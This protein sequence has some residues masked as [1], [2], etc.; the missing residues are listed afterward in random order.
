MEY[1]IEKLL[2]GLESQRA[3]TLK[4]LNELNEN[5]PNYALKCNELNTQIINIDNQITNLILAL[6]DL[7]I[8]ELNNDLTIKTSK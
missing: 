5:L 8:Q 4:T 1:R 7:K 3:S 6:K 2:E